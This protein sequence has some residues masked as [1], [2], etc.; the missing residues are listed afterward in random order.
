V[1]RVATV[2]LVMVLGACAAPLEREAPPAPAPEP[3]V[4][5]E[6]ATTSTGVDAD[7]LYK[8]LVAEFAGRRGELDLAVSSYLEV[9]RD[10]RDPAVAERAVRVAVFARDQQGGLEAARLWTE[11][12]PDSKEAQQVYATLL[13]RGGEVTLA[14]EH[15]E[16][17]VASSGDAADQQLRR[18]AQLLNHEKDREAA[19]AVM[20]KLAERYP[21][22][23]DA[24]FGLARLLARASK[25]EEATTVLTAVLALDGGNE[26][27]AV[28]R[29][30]LLQRQDRT[31]DALAGL[32]GFLA[33]N[34][35]ARSARTA[36]AR[37]LVDA[38]RYEDARGEF[39]RLV[40][41]VP[42]NPDLRYA[43][44]LLL[45]Q[46]ERRNQAE[47]HFRQL[48]EGRK[49]RDSAWF[50]L[51]QI[52]EAR[53]GA[54]E[55]LADYRRVADGEH[56]LDA[57]VR[58]ALLLSRQGRIDEA[59]AYLRGYRSR[60]PAEAIRI[61]RAE[62]EL[63]TRAERFADAMAVY[64]AALEEFPQNSDLLYARAMVAE[65]MGRIDLLERDLRSVLARDPDNADALNALG[66][67]LADRT[68]RLEEALGYIE[69][70]YAIKPD[71][72]YVVDSMG[73]VMYRMGRH[74]EALELL[75][76]AFG[77]RGD[78]EIAAHLGE[79][80]WVTGARDEA[81]KI[82]QAALQ[83][84]P[85]HKALREVIQRFSE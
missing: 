84:T 49:R 30:R 42:D 1:R 61:H 69:R 39:E 76:R 31:A 56:A 57:R 7:T 19:L 45:L 17:L 8:L 81:R 53:G 20:R 43:L 10:T 28:L 72:H 18:I 58:A 62:A 66:Y 74:R 2:V 41:S 46:T 27:A 78:P 47:P 52:A 64:D 11:V 38:K 12:A 80:L 48:A 5:S 32:A 50:Y 73:W 37:L 65:K 13:V 26:S 60:A 44:A 33:A 34:P 70:A 67:T 82:W 63:L 16:R 22:S 4:A 40:T 55:A 68:D 85:D 83:G 54:E 21:E 29:A 15:F 59:R 14:V 25:L 71:D 36:Y 75:R 51:G 35:E 9:A 77:M 6:P 24:Q 3:A 23:V 79:V